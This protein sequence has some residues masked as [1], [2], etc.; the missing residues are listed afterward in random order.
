M[1][2]R[3]REGKCRPASEG[4]VGQGNRDVEPR[5]EGPRRQVS[6]ENTGPVLA[7]SGAE[8]TGSVRKTAGVGESEEGSARQG[9]CVSLGTQEHSCLRA[10]AFL[11]VLGESWP[12]S[13]GTEAVE[14]R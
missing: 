12:R 3:N 13:L 10:L 2:G 11:K 14:V 4:F 1:V 5:L 7:W 6:L 8:S 9:T